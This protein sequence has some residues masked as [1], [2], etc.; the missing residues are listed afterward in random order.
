MENLAEITTLMTRLSQL[1][2]L[3][4]RE[5]WAASVD[6]FRAQLPRDTAY[7]LS[8]IVALYGGMG[9]IND[10]ALYRNGQPLI[11]EN[12]E[13]AALRSVLYERCVGCPSQRETP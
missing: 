1:L 2:S 4:G 9:S 6:A 5:D 13:L 11:A 8:R 7:T 12:N 3:G 10:I